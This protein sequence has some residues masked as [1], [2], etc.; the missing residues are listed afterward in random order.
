MNAL[1]MERDLAEDSDFSKVEIFLSVTDLGLR[2]SISEVLR[3]IG[4]RTILVGQTLTEILEHLQ[5]NTPDLLICS[6][7]F[8]DGELFPKVR[9]LRHHKWGKNPF[10]PIMTVT[11]QPSNEMVKEVLESGVDDLLIQPISTGQLRDRISGL[12]KNRKQFVVTTDYVGPTRRA[13]NSD[14][15]TEIPMIDVPNTLRT[16]VTGEDEAVDLSVAIKNTL[17]E[18]NEQKVERHGFQLAYLA[19]RIVDPNHPNQLINDSATLLD[20]LIAVAEETRDRM[21]STRYAHTSTLCGS[22]LEVA[23]SIRDAGGSPVEKDL[24]LLNPLAQ[25]ILI[26]FSDSE[27]ASAANAIADKVA[28]AE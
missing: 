15:G 22:I 13:N 27:A 5:D 16:K 19:E 14:R 3:Y 20:D 12:A 18:I 9:E 4:V 8:P 25:A 2:T 11:D 1:G 6:A 23:H 26:G 24:G 7:H 17:S 21:E 10:I 28:Q